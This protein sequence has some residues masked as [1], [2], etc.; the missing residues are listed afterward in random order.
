MR[1]GRGAGHQNSG[2]WH[3]R[4]NLQLLAGCVDAIQHN[5]LSRTQRH[6]ARCS[7]RLPPLLQLQLLVVQE[8]D[9]SLTLL[10]QAADFNARGE[11]RHD[12]GGE[13]VG[14]SEGLKAVAAVRCGA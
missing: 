3:A 4:E 7:N 5:L 10:D 13:S 11:A 14:G 8:G 2:H 1:E 9:G 12:A 6:G